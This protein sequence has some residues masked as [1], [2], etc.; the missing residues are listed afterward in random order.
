MRFFGQY[1]KQRARIIFIF[2]GFAAVFGISFALYKLPLEAVMYPVFLCTAAGIIIAAAD[3]SIV[4]KKH[5][6]LSEIKRLSASMMTS[7]PNAV[8]IDDR[9]YQDIIEALRDEA[10]QR[11]KLALARYRDMTEYYTV[12]AH[13][14]KTPIASMQLAL[15]NEDTA[16]S[17]KLSSDLFRIEQYVQMVMAFL[18]LESVST[19]YFFGEYDLDGIIKQ[20][21][22]KFASEFVGRKIK[23]EYSPAGKT[24]VT[25]EKWLSFVLEQLLSNALKYT[26]EGCI[27]I[28][29]KEPL[30]LCVEDTG[31]G[32]A[33]EDLPRIF[34]NG[35]TGLNGRADKKASGIG[36][37]LC[38]RICDNLNIGISVQSELGRGTTVLLDMEQYKTEKE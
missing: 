36:L 13:Q 12:W 10:A 15:Q 7:L 24:A 30:T 22:A 28:Y 20:A 18:R 5:K 32:I 38:K 29:F 17:R 27:R 19:D 9:D 26:K 33:S 1:I 34:E 11:E 14:I 3:L 31:I 4:Y 25:D 16:L 6:K 23:L 35:Y 8:T 2:A 37:Y 21:V